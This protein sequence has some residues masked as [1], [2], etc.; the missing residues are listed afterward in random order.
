MKQSC[1]V[2][3]N[4]AQGRLHGL[5]AVRFLMQNESLTRRSLPGNSSDNDLTMCIARFAKRCDLCSHGWMP[6]EKEKT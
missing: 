1:R 5:Q 6:R 4:T 3:R 2:L